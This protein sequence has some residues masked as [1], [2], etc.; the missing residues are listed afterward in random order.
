[1]KK[2]YINSVLLCM[3]LFI[4]PT[5]FKITCHGFN[6]IESVVKVPPK[7]NACKIIR[8]DG[9]EEQEN[10]TCRRSFLKLW[11][12]SNLVFVAFVSSKSNA[13]VPEDDVKILKDGLDTLTALVDNWERA[14]VDCNYADV[15]R[16]LLEQKNKDL[17]LEKASTWALF[18]KSTSVVSCKRTNRL[19]RDYIGLTGKGPLV[20]AERR[21]LRKQII[22]LVDPE[23]IDQYFS[24]EL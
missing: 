15:P 5:L 20:G 8:Y 24:G 23:L 21:M 10:T 2:W 14:T 9:V 17:L 13:A 6:F 1:M 19:V 16:E 11:G 3:L 22:N 18:D 12:V 7:K 4:S